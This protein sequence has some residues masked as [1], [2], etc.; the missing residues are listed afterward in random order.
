MAHPW[1]TGVALSVN[2][3]G[4]DLA[5]CEF[6]P[7][8]GLCADSSEPASDSVCVCVCVCVCARAHVCV[9]LS[10]PLPHSSSASLSQK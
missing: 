5:V 1:G 7:R 3:S 4:H 9:S 10:L 6:E 2:R 8:V